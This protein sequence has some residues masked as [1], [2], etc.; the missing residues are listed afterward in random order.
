MTISRESPLPLYS[1]IRQE[2]EQSIHEGQW[3]PGTR[4]PSEDQL[5]AQFAVSRLTV[6]RAID[7]LVS[8][9]TLR[10]VQGQGTFVAEPRAR[11][12]AMG[13][14]RWSFERVHQGLSVT[15]QVLR[16]EEVSPS[17]RVAHLL[18]TMPNEPI[19]QMTRLLSLAGGPLGYSIDRIPR[20]L[21]PGV[22][23]WDL[24]EDS[25]PAFLARRCSFDFGKVEERVRAVPAD[26]DAA[27][28]LGVAPGD[29]LLHID[30]LVFLSSGIPVILSDIS[31]CGERY[32]YQ[33]LMH[34]LMKEGE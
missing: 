18:H 30:S 14:T 19:V 34:P 6:R 27:E 32:V 3:A 17:L 20:L 16:V 31:Y 23:E 7:Q 28:L 11:P 25:L 15:K 12:K 9:G 29:P 10:R 8:Q 5:A 22:D 13:I 21:V 33:G 24:G 26:E 4:L 1:Q 2:I